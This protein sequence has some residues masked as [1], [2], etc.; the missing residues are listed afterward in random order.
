MTLPVSGAVPQKTRVNNIIRY[1]RTQ[2]GQDAGYGVEV[3]LSDAQIVTAI[4]DA[5]A[6]YS[7]W[8]PAVSY[9]AFTAMVGSS[10]HTPD[11]PLSDI[12]NL[13]MIPTTDLAIQ[14]VPHIGFYNGIVTG[15]GTT[16][17]YN[18]PFRYA[19]FMEWKQATEMVFSQVPSWVFLPEANK[20]YI[21]SPSKMT[22]VSIVGS[23]ARDAA[24]DE[25]ELWNDEEVESENPSSPKTDRL[26][27]S[28]STVKPD[29]MI[30]IRELTLARSMVILGRMRSKYGS[31]PQVEG[32]EVQL[33]GDAMKTEGNTKWE[34][35]LREVKR[36]I[37]GKYMPV[38]A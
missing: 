23:F 28:L 38:F 17:D 8:H 9:Q 11:P 19:A 2:L 1:V 16:V 21:Y 34:E 4:R 32:K 14:P 10:V 35:I 36:S 24:F 6:N 22:K 29:H 5:L 26:D 20:L 18:M 33:D 12:I 13:S 31:I 7:K 37:A 3:E 15:Y 27:L 25:E 30:W